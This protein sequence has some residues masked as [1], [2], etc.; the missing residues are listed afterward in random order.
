MTAQNAPANIDVRPLIE[1]AAEQVAR[2]SAA[3]NVA[4][5]TVTL[6]CRSTVT[7]GVTGA[8]TGCGAVGV[9]VGR[10]LRF[11]AR[12]LLGALAPL[13]LGVRRVGWS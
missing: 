9:T 13:P 5:V 3:T 6:L 4:A 2:A 12:S 8:V 10:R 11:L 1:K 7:V